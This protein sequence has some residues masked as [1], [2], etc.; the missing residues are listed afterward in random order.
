MWIDTIQPVRI[1]AD[2]PIYVLEFAS[3]MSTTLS[4]KMK[5]SWLQDAVRRFGTV[6]VVSGTQVTV[7]TICN[8]VNAI[9]DV[10]DTNLFPIT[11]FKYSYDGVPFGFPFELEKW[12]ME[13]KSN[14]LLSYVNPQANIV[15]NIGGLYLDCPIGNWVVGYQAQPLVESNGNSLNIIMRVGLSNSPDTIGNA[16]FISRIRLGVGASMPLYEEDSFSKFAL[17]TVAQKT[18]FY[19]NADTP[20]SNMYR[21][22]YRG[23]VSETIIRIVSGYI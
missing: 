5:V 3:D 1:Q 20:V 19:L 21:L 16:G 14:S 10:L 7:L 22:C 23:D 18:R 4:P 2:D 6:V 12:S 11:E 9:Y 8:S 15:Y 13:L 17:M